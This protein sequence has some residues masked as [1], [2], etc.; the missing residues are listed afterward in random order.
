MILIECVSARND[1]EDEKFRFGEKYGLQSGFLINVL[2]VRS[3][4]LVR[5][6]A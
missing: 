4:T 5:D 3:S 1:V 2:F 6:F